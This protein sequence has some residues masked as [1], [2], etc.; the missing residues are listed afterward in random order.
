MTPFVGSTESELASEAGVWR[1]EVSVIG[2]G[3]R[4]YSI[5][6]PA[7]PASCVRIL[8]LG[9]SYLNIAEVYVYTGTF[10][11]QFWKSERRTNV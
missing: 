5:Q 3:R 8:T 7:V 2:G 4:S 9:S 10:T 1:K 6:V 11:F